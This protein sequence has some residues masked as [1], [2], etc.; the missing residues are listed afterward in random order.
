MPPIVLTVLQILFLL[1]LYLFVARAVRAVVRDVAPPAAPAGTRR[2]PRAEPE[3]PPAAQRAHRP[4]SSQGSHP[5]QPSAPPARAAPGELVVHAT[6]GAPWRLPLNGDEI[7]LGRG[8]GA[9]VSLGDPYT[10]DRH[11]SLYREGGEWLVVDLGSTNGTFLNQVKVTGPT[12]IAAGDQ[13]GLGRTVIEVR[14]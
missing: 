6:S 4:E 9:S 2:R 8:E 12:P 11:A 7:T 14:K 1:L 10:S 5:S 3:P 13:L